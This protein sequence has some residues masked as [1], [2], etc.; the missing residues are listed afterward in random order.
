[1][2]SRPP[3]HREDGSSFWYPLWLRG[4]ATHDRGFA[5]TAHAQGR[6]SDPADIAMPPR[7]VM[8]RCVSGRR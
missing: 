2:T 8:L 1:M 4:A 6:F 5:V 7:A 3:R